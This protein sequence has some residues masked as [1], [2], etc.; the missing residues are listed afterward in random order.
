M[1][2]NQP[3][4]GKYALNY[5][6]LVGGVSVI[7]GIMLYTMDMQYERGI[8]VQGTQIAIA[9]VGI[10]LGI[11]QFKKANSDFLQISEALKIGAGV[12]L[13]AGIIGL[14]YFFVLSNFIQP[15]Y[16][17]QMYE[18]GKQ[19]ALQN[20][21]KLTEEQIDQGIEMQKEFAWV[22]YPIIIIFN[23]L[24]GLLVGLIG[25]LIFKKQKPAY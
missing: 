24:I 12:A 18:I 23:I 9:V 14:I 11:Y 6:L 10:L 7:F 21:P 17:D 1:E 16:M 19:E 5:G 4:T 20:N 3:K 13:I 15:D 8:A 2:E 25:G 22:T